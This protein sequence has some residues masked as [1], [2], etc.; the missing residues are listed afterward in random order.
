MT[1]SLLFL[2]C[3]THFRRG[4][5]DVSNC[6]RCGKEFEKRGVPLFVISETEPCALYCSGYATYE[7]DLCLECS[8]ELK[9]FMNMEVAAHGLAE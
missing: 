8:E 3:L 1:S 2:F 6:E 4:G 5:L 9:K 7:V